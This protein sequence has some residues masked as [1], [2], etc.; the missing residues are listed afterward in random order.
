MGFITIQPP[1]FKGEYLLSFFPTTVS[2]QFY[3]SSPNLVDLMIPSPITPDFRPPNLAGLSY[4]PFSFGA[5]DDCGGIIS[6][7]GRE[8]ER[9]GNVH[10]ES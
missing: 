6:K 3:I 4:S 7:G 10:C 5:S 9:G 2:K 8:G 1:P